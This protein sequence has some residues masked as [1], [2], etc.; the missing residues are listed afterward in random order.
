MASPIQPNTGGI[1][2][3]SQGPQQEQEKLKGVADKV[4]LATGGPAF[5]KI[6]KASV[7]QTAATATSAPGPLNAATT[8]KQSLKKDMD[9]ETL[10]K[11]TAPVRDIILNGLSSSELN[12][13]DYALS[14]GTKEKNK[15]AFD[16]LKDQITEIKKKRNEE[17]LKEIL[18]D[19]PTWKVVVDSWKNVSLEDTIWLLQLYELHNLGVDIHP[20]DEIDDLRKPSSPP[21]TPFAV[22]PHLLKSKQ[23]ITAHLSNIKNLDY[24]GKGLKKCPKAISLLVNLE[25]LNLGYNKLTSPPDVSQNLNLKFLS[26]GSNQLKAPPDVK[27]NGKL[28]NL[29]LENN[30]L[31]E[32][33]NISQNVEL[34]TLRLENNKLTKAPDISPNVN[35]QL[36]DICDNP[37]TTEA[38]DALAQL[39][40]VR[41]L[42]TIRI[43]ES[44]VSL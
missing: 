9:L 17:L 42:V 3:S 43:K 8:V 33:P 40:K 14:K 15:I 41:K 19:H 16:K 44:D 13:F 29:H 20:I 37:L 4:S 34:T 32:L 11:I 31:T 27:R 2:P 24:A 21:F 38:Q 6:T 23:E 39:K 18:A 1:Q 26:L 30:Q 35:M 12:D 7:P 36:L 10:L 5:Q 22:T 25:H 28:E